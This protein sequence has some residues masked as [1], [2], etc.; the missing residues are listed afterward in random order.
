MGI[1]IGGYWTGLANLFGG[2]R[3]KER[4]AMMHETG[5]LGWVSRRLRKKG[6]RGRPFFFDSGY[7][8][9]ALP[10]DA[11]GRRP[12]STTAALR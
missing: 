7:I 12:M 2:A 5:R 4:A 9:D 1:E 3:E 6:K 10:V 8:V 11:V